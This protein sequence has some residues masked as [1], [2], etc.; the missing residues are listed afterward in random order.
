M[1]DKMGCA[2]AELQLGGGW[3]AMVDATFGRGWS[4]F[5][6]YVALELLIEICL[7]VGVVAVGWSWSWGDPRVSVGLGS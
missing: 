2:S 5:C 4:L 1:S 6:C 3:C 7:V